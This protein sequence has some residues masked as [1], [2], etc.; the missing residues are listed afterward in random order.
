MAQTVCL[1]GSFRHWAEMLECPTP[2]LHRDPVTMTGDEARAAI[3][4]HL[5]RIDRAERIFV[6]DK[7]GYAS[8]IFSRACARAM[9]GNT[10]RLTGAARVVNFPDHGRL[11]QLAERWPHMPEV[12][13]SSPVSST[14][15]PSSA[16]REVP[17][18]RRTIAPVLLLLLLTAGCTHSGGSSLE[19]ASVPCLPPGLNA[20]FFSW[21]VVGF[22]PVTLVTE[23]G[24]DVE[25]AWVLYRRG[26]ASIAAIWTRSDLVDVHP[27]PDTEEP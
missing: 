4:A 3:L 13:G 24:D 20:Q 7:E 6:Y 17:R 2:E 27:H 26:G 23:G 11:A 1:C 22:E 8:R 19:L 25:A 15:P 10:P 5:D 21:P 9:V 14:I 16:P 18:M 12:T